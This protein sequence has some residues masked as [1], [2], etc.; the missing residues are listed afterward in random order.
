[1]FYING[2]I[3]TM[4][5][6]II[7]NGYLSVQDGKIAA[8]GEMAD[9]EKTAGREPAV[10]L[11]GAFVCPG[12]ID[13]H[14]HLGM[15]EDGLGFEG[16]DGNEET[17]PATPQLRATDAVNPM[18]RC[19]R[20]AL[21]AGI[22]TVVTGPG[23]ANPIGG[24][25][26]AMKTYGNRVDGM[27]LRDPL[28][29]KMALGENP[30]SVYHGKGQT[31][32]TRMATAA[33]IRE[34]LR[35][36]RRYME[37]LERAQEDPDCDPPEFDIK[38]E[39]L[40]PLLRKEIPAHIHCH[41][42]DD[43]FTAIRIAKEFDLKLVIVHG[44]EGGLIAEDLVKEG[45]PVLSGPI[46]CDRSK[47]E[48]RNL[49]PATP[50]VLSRAGIKTC[51]VTDHPVIPIQ[52]LPVCAGLAVREGMNWQSAL[53]A[54]TRNPAEVCGISDRVG[55]LAAGMDADF[56]VFDE[57]PFTLAAKPRMVFAGGVCVVNREK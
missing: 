51:L 38:C 5:G 4:S 29:V 23:S 6:G 33:I 53:E 22:T 57:E 1:M 10:D 20:E 17:D 24:T 30:K 28:A 34:H 37:E 3:H 27:L 52:Y 44:T 40:L 43:I 21:E 15:W 50:G 41:R 8:V 55:A 19:F 35:K 12:F 7:R 47:P 14:T 2:E 9:W 32:V 39:S 56:L 42:A 36:A 16:D 13:A 48:L 45:A 49:S 46:L 25:L 26:I 31:P 11:H 18:D 54:I